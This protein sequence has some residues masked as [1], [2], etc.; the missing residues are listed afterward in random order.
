MPP[1][2]LHPELAASPLAVHM[3][4]TRA[5]QAAVHHHAHHHH[6]AHARML[7]WTPSETVDISSNTPRQAQS[8]SAQTP[9]VASN[10]TAELSLSSLEVTT[11]SPSRQHRNAQVEAAARMEASPMRHGLLPPPPLPP[12]PLLQDS[13]FG[14][15]PGAPVGYSQAAGASVV[16]ETG[17]V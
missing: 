15:F 5:H 9:N 17:G 3:L 14:G 1:P 13:I 2:P 16:A 4:N 10:T 7:G 11:R 12:A 8:E 6:H